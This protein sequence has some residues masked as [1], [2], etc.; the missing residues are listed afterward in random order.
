MRIWDP[1]TG[2][3]TLRADFLATVHDL[4][5]AAPEEDVPVATVRAITRV[6]IRSAT[7]ATAIP[8]VDAA[9]TDLPA[10]ST[11][12][13]RRFP[14]RRD[15]AVSQSMA[16]V[17]GRVAI[18]RVQ[19]ADG[20]HHVDGAITAWSGRAAVEVGRSRY[21][22][23]RRFLMAGCDARLAARPRGDPGSHGT[24]S[25]CWLPVW[26]VLKEGECSSGCCWSMPAMSSTCPVQDRR[27][28]CRRAVPAARGGAA[29]EQ[30]RPTNSQPAAGRDAVP[31]AA[32]P[33]PPRA[34]RRCSPSSPR[35]GCV[36]G[37]P[38]LFGR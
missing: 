5:A 21:G 2:G 18:R 7:G 12:A 24:I 9:H 29:G 38:S 27:Q 11:R 19:N 22:P 33:S 34:T 15:T 28:G 6:G 31:Q 4:V 3:V 25:S 26:C 20:D 16:A 36:P 8:P 14:G 13:L 37:S 23:S 35:H 17:T 32:D 30:F 1:A 10:G